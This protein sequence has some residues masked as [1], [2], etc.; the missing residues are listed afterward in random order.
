MRIWENASSATPVASASRSCTPVV[1]TRR[2]RP[3]KIAEP[4]T[5]GET[6]SAV[7]VSFGCSQV[8]RMT[9]PTSERI[10]R[11]NSETWWLSTPC[12]SPTSEV[13]RLVS[14]PVRRSAKKPGG[15]SSSRANSSFRSPA[16][17]RSPTALSTYACT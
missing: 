8:S 2:R 16:T 15:I 9:P 4:T 5:S 17:D 3:K 6:A 7:S 1:M 12:S 10:C 11:A 14:S 13:R